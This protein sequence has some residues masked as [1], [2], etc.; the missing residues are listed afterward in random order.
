V[1]GREF[2]GPSPGTGTFAN[3]FRRIRDL[4]SGD[5]YSSKTDDR[6]VNKI[7]YFRAGTYYI[8][9]YIE[10]ASGNNAGRMAV[11]DTAKPVA[12]IAYPGATPTVDGRCSALSPQIGSRPCNYGAHIALYGNGHNTYIDGLRFV[13]MAVHA[14]RTAG[15]G[16]Y[17]VFRRNRFA[18]NGPTVASV[19]QG[20]ITTIAASEVGHSGSYLSI[21]DNV[22]EDIE[23]GVCVKLYSTSRV[24][25]EDNI[26]RN[27][28]G[29]ESEG[30]ALKGGVMDRV[31]VRHN[32]ISNIARHG[33]AGNMHFLQS[34]EILFNR[35][36]QSAR[37]VVEI[38]QDGVAGPVHVYR[39]TLV[40]RVIVRNTDSTDGPFYFHNNVIINDDPGNHIYLENVSDTSRVRITDN[41]TGTQSQGIVDANL[42]LTSGYLSYLGTRGY[43]IQGIAGTA[44]AP[45][46][47]SNVRV[48]RE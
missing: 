31:T 43:Q 40:G 44:P 21:Q 30:F 12:W 7:A 32:T 19:N 47:P 46:A 14:F 11:L 9:G 36:S 10:D 42:N 26:C 38:N 29:G 28:R 34:A 20:F 27:V 41:L 15:T 8:D 37:D 5:S 17:Q 1:N 18:I 48:I 16:N 4:Y 2:D 39:N 23:E 33:I 24:L 6:H 25:I 45:S 13:N 3:P 35:V 22:F